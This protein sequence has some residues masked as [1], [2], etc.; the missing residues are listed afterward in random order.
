MKMF[1]NDKLSIHEGFW[2]YELSAWKTRNRPIDL[3]G[4]NVYKTV[5]SCW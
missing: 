4:I 2:K 5:D 3:L 1:G